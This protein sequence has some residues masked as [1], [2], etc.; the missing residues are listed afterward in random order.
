MTFGWGADKETARRLF[1]VY[2][3]A[4]GNFLDTA[5]M[6]SGG[7]S[8]E[9]LGELIQA[10]KARDD[11]VLATKFSFSAQQGNPNAGGNGRK[12]I[13]RALE[14]SLRRLRTDYLDL[15]IMHTWDRATPVE[16]VASTL[17][18]LVRC[19]KIRHVGLSDVPAWYAAR[20]T[21]MADLRGWERPA[22]LQLE[23]SLVARNL[24][25]EHLP[26]AQELGISITPWS[27]LGSG[28]LTGKF[29]RMEGRITGAGRVVDVKDSGNPV[30]ERFAKREQNWKILETL[31][32]VA[33]GLGRPPAEIALAWVVGRPCITS[34]LI[35]ATRVEQLE[36][37]LASAAV[38]LPEDAARVLDEA[39][40]LEPNELDHFFDRVLQG[41]VNGGTNVARTFF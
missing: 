3:E 25:R 34:T 21:T 38:S 35:G 4:G 41:M 2:R 28:F 24:E 22:S 27:P 7:V 30:L 32:E 6:Y 14:G 36:A 13:L 26:L 1:E 37:N 40:A 17:N 16:E 11:V 5:D 29:R 8:E 31:L 18:D 10:G 23:Y 20:F 9:W 12:N 39:S 19:G 33:R 15:Y